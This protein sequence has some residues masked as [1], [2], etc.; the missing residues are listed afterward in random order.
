MSREIRPAT[1]AQ[2]DQ[3][4]TAIRKLREARNLLTQAHCPRATQY[5]RRAL[6]SAGGAERHIHHRLRRTTDAE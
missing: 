5:V 2:L 4:R 6:A 3:V 1:H